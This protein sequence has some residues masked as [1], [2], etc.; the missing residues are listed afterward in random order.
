MIIVQ[1]GDSLDLAVSTLNDEPIIALDTETN[2][3]DNMHERWVLGFSAYAPTV[4]E[5]YYFPIKHIP[6]KDY[7]NVTKWST[8]LKPQRIVFHNG[9]FDRQI[10]KKLEFDFDKVPFE[11]TMLM[12]Y[13]IYEEPPHGLKELAD[14]YLRSDSSNDQKIV[15]GLTKGFGWESMPMPIMAQYAT[16]DTILTYKLYL[17]LRDVLASTGEDQM[18]LYLNDLE[19]S[20]ILQGI[21]EIG[22]MIDPVEARLKSAQCSELMLKIR[23]ELGYD[24][25][26]PTQLGNRLYSPPPDGLGLRPISVGLTTKS[27]P[28]GRPK[29]GV[30]ELEEHSH[31]EVGRVLE[32][33][34]VSKARSSWYDAW[35]LL[36]DSNNRL[37]PTF[38]M[39]ATVTGR[40]SCSNPNMQQIPRDSEENSTKSLF[41]VKKLIRCSKGYQVWEMD[42][43][44]QELRLASIYADEDAMLEVFRSKGDP[45]QLMADTLHV[46]RFIGKTVN[47]LL[48]YGGGADRL[49][50]T[51]KKLAPSLGFTYREAMD[52]HSEYHNKY[53]GFRRIAYEC[54]SAMER[55]GY[56][57]YWSKRRRHMRYDQHKAFNS[58]IQGGCAD[59]TRESMRRI[60]RL[61]LSN[62]AMI[63]QVHDSIWFETK[64]VKEL[65]PIKHAMEDWVSEAF[66]L[67]F[68]VGMKQIA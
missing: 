59:I 7:A 33:R 39:H 2:I 38:H 16:T 12:S 51:I 49:F 58:L 44:Q 20:L 47:F 9:K 56:I 13:V 53:P 46:S 66:G 8:L 24:P 36:I 62:T 4:D 19:F 32:Y 60:V 29:M 23:N 61:D 28:N 65:E 35:P 15:K 6:F 45:H 42:Y 48:P 11:D 43:D 26:K 10:F 31:P 50:G 21:E 54:Q 25:A 1:N 40:L 22:I 37:H 67:P 14:K 34:R 52:I 30:A 27:F 68:S 3:C 18:R 5:S 63:S 55:V 17:V 57:K 64:D 41:P